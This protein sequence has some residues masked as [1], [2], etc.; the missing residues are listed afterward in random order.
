MT[1]ALVILLAQAPAPA[2]TGD[3]SVVSKCDISE[4][5]RYG[6][7]MDTPIRV[8]GL[9]MYGAAR[10]HRY[11]RALAGPAGQPVAFRRRGAVGPNKDE[12][13]IDL[14]EVSYAGL[15]KPI[16]LYLDFYRWDP[17]KAPRGFVCATEIGLDEPTG[18][19]ESHRELAAF[20]VKAGLREE[21]PPMPLGADGSTRYGVVIDPFRYIASAARALAA[22]GETVTPEMMS[23]IFG[24]QFIVIAHP[25]SCDGQTRMPR[26]IGLRRGGRP[27]PPRRGPIDDAMLQKVF[28]WMSAPDGAIGIAFAGP[29][30]P[31]GGEVVL[32]YDGP[33]CPSSSETV[34]LPVRAEPP[35]TSGDVAPVWPADVNPSSVDAPVVVEVRARIGIDGVPGGLQA[36]SGP[37][38][39]AE[40]AMDAVRRW[41]FTPFTINGAPAYAPVVITIRVSFGGG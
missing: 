38:A 4:D 10:Q 25:L 14:Y 15:E 28:P 33:A 19:N 18:P 24:E 36:V 23:G 8:G 5:P 17:P 22:T 34:T 11:L 26:A 32:T 31:P 9:P 39:F 3:R 1:A 29:H 40:A 35:T 30:L 41:R 13:L 12:V 6:Y 20:A 2:V 27:L 21:V 16:E 37:D 7:S